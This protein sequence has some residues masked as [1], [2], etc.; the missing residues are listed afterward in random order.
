MFILKFHKKKLPAEP[1]GSTECSFG[2]VSIYN[3]DTKLERS[4]LQDLNIEY[5]TKT[6]YLYH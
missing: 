2:I 4:N 6:I 1:K 5:S 3:Y